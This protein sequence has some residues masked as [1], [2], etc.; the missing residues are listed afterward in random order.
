MKVYTLGT[1]QRQHFEFTKLLNKYGVQV[2]LDIRRSPA[3]P[4]APQFSRDGLQLLCSSQ[5]A[6]YIYLGNDFAGGLDQ[7][8]RPAQLDPNDARARTTLREWQASD[9]FQRT[10]KIVTAK[11][12]TRVTCV[13][14]SERTPEDCYRLF[15]AAEL[16][17][18]GFE[19]VHILD[20]TRLWTA[21]LTQRRRPPA[22]GGS[23][24]RRA[25]LAR[26]GRQQGSNRPLRADRH[27]LQS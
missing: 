18:A 26:G 27:D 25:D 21:P 23:H 17:R 3:S 6:E 16:A 11:A 1:A 14:C 19:V 20:E 12:T 7:E 5:R 15:L 8:L 10:L 9:G 24:P 13:L 2:V 4:G 22:S